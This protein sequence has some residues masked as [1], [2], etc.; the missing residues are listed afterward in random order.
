MLPVVVAATIGAVIGALRRP[1]GRHLATP[2]LFAPWLLIAGVALQVGLAFADLGTEGGLLALSLALFAVFCVLNRQLPGMG[3]LAI[4]LVCNVAVVAVNGAMPVRI[5]ALVD[6]GAVS[7]AEL[8]SSELGAGR[9][10]EQTDDVVPW[11]GDAIPI[12]PFRAAMSYGDLIALFGTAAVAGELARYA[13]RGQ[14]WHLL[15]DF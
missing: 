11:L 6:S 7:L 14:R 1:H 8:T 12:R 5:P 13:R 9:R 2:R 15:P 3:V 4:G 10:F